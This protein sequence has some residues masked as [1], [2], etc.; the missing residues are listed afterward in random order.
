ME[1]SKQKKETTC[2]DRVGVGR[3]SIAPVCPGRK[4]NLQPLLQRS[5]MGGRL[6]K[7]RTA[8]KEVAP[9][10]EQWPAEIESVAAEAI[11]T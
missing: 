3:E 9:R 7:H 6:G 11:K 4:E 8:S 10:Q 5:L 1:T 2:K